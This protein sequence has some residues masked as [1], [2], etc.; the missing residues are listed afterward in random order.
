MGSQVGVGEGRTRPLWANQGLLWASE[1]L[2]DGAPKVT[3]P[4]EAPSVPQEASR[5]QTAQEVFSEKGCGRG[6]CSR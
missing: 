2:G 1:A 5:H 4:L 6:L 3:L